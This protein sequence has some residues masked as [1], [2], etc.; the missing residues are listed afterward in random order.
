[1]K[2]LV[3]V[4]GMCLLTG[5][6][7]VTEKFLPKTEVISVPIASTFT[8]EGVSFPTNPSTYEE[9]VSM[10]ETMVEH[11]ILEIDVPYAGDFMNGDLY[12]MY[13][14]AYGKAYTQVNITHIE[15]TCNTSRYLIG[16]RLT[17]NGEHYIYMVLSDPDFTTDEILYQQ[18]SFQE[19]VALLVDKMYDDGL[20]YEGQT[21]MEIL[22][23][24]YQF[25][26]D[27]LDY[28]Y[29][30]VPESFTGYA[31]VTSGRVV[32]QG[33]VALFNSLAKCLGFEAEGVAGVVGVG[34]YA[35]EE[36]HIWSRVKVGDEWL[37]FDP[38][39]A[40][41]SSFSEESGDLSYN[42]EYFN[43]SYDDMIRDR[44]TTTFGF[45]DDVLQP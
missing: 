44:T 27:H 41:R 17:A 8:V 34:A 13:E 12:G 45:N 29:E 24:L 11:H 5:C 1:M 42:M 14:L 39:F 16:Y 28:S 31:A 43:M 19:E 22:Q 40:D 2:K 38:T 26:T 23:V 18:R 3:L 32:C 10:L 21:E 33:Y 6:A 36:G 15:Y 20:L 7:V 37:Y 30:I 9:I 25:V 35:M 4:M